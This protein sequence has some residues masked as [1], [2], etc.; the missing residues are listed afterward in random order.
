MEI[1]VGTDIIEINRIKE[2]IETMGDKFKQRVF[3]QKEIDY[4]ESKNSQKY[5]H[6]AARFAG[7]EAVFKAIS[8]KLDNKFDIAWTDIEITNDSQNRPQVEILN[9]KVDIQNIDISLSHCKTFAI[10]NVVATF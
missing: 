6:Y 4:C 5:Q 8:K 10:S 1:N 3:T 2:S 7:K 9:K